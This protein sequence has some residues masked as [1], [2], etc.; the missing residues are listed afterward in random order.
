MRTR[1]FFKLLGVGVLAPF[2]FFVVGV[3]APVLGLVE[4]GVAIPEVEAELKPLDGP[5]NGTSNPIVLKECRLD[6]CRGS[7]CVC[8]VSVRRVKMGKRWVRG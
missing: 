3:L 7:V 6:K 1:T 8:V 5:S 4:L 2:E